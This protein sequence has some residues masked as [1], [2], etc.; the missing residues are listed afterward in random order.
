M[1]KYVILCFVCLGFSYAY[2]ASA[3]SI[4]KATQREIDSYKKNYIKPISL[5]SATDMW[6]GNDKNS[7]SFLAKME[8]C[9]KDA[10]DPAY[11]DQQ[12]VTIN[13][14]NIITLP[15]N[16]SVSLS[17]SP[18]PGK[19]IKDA[20]YDQ[21]TTSLSLSFSTNNQVSAS[22]SL[23][24]PISSI[25]ESIYYIS[26][27]D[28]IVE[29][30]DYG[31]ILDSNFKH[32]NGSVWSDG[33]GVNMSA[34]KRF[35]YGNFDATQFTL[36]NNLA[37]EAGI[38][39]GY[40]IISDTLNPSDLRDSYKLQIQG[41]YYFIFNRSTGQPIKFFTTTK[42]TQNLYGSSNQPELK[43][44][45]K[46]VTWM[47]NTSEAS[48]IREFKTWK[49]YKNLP[50]EWNNTPFFMP[51]TWNIEKVPYTD[52]TGY[53][54]LVGRQSVYLK[55][56]PKNNKTSKYIAIG[57]PTKT[58][59]SRDC[60]ATPTTVMHVSHFLLPVCVSPGASYE[61]LRTAHILT[62]GWGD[63]LNSY[64]TQAF[65]N[66]TSVTSW[67]TVDT[68][69]LNFIENADLFKKLSIPLLSG[70]HADLFQP[71]YSAGGF[72]SIPISQ[73]STTTGDQTPTGAKETI[74]IVSPFGQKD[75][76][77]DLVGPSGLT[78]SKRSRI[79]LSFIDKSK[80]TI[81]SCAGIAVSPAFANSNHLSS[82]NIPLQDVSGNTQC[83][84]YPGTIFGEQNNFGPV[85]M[86]L[87]KGTVNFKKLGQPAY[88][89]Q[90][91]SVGFTL[92][93]FEVGDKYLV[94]TFGQP[95]TSTAQSLTQ[96]YMNNFSMTK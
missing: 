37:S 65:N 8:A 4:S 28:I 40:V 89:L 2:G 39:S 79:T 25:P 27:K 57:Y 21:A 11:P 69:Q 84:F 83:F 16:S 61:T 71:T 85:T 46:F 18:V 33:L 72:I 82:S 55:L 31:N 62:V 81:K 49:Q 6:E 12:L 86:V 50:V 1:K 54:A 13:C 32:Y 92:Y 14:T 47:T 42:L 88:V 70:W 74:L 34:I 76:L 60:G 78:D 63:Y 67:G 75:Y 53:D 56:T 26:D 90:N 77:E 93:L 73:N 15:V 68:T 96:Y 94:T 38:S 9:I 48:V 52:T 43:D 45:K 3:V 20:T 64:S 19:K 59:N 30:K 29:K 36:S 7:N 23:I 95:M 80:V 87:N 17:I 35:Y 41:Q 51:N 58:I 22:S 10:N 91:I 44:A 66:K 24:L 5:F